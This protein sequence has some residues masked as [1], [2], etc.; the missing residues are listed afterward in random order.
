[1]QYMDR[2]YR[3]YRK[4]CKSLSILVH[5]TLDTV[6]PVWCTKSIT[7]MSA[8][9]HDRPFLSK[10]RSKCFNRLIISHINI[11]PN[12]MSKIEHGVKIRYAIILLRVLSRSTSSCPVFHLKAYSSW[13]YAIYNNNILRHEVLK[14]PLSKDQVCYFVYWLLSFQ[15]N[16]IS[17]A[18]KSKALVASIRN[19]YCRH[20]GGVHLIVTLGS[21]S[22]AEDDQ[23]FVGHNTTNS[24][25]LTTKDN[26]VKNNWLVIVV[27]ILELLSLH[28]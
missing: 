4:Y 5:F 8:T 22:S 15:I 24:W 25:K 21:L 18:T 28:E 19:G 11:L 14:H 12:C 3:N 16:D 23:V 9:F 26:V 20:F 2:C 17:R 6:W 7:F 1:M 27:M 10:I 13:A